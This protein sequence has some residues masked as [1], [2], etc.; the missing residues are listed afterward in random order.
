[1]IDR[2]ERRKATL[3]LTLMLALAGGCTGDSADGTVPPKG[4]EP[5]PVRLVAA[6]AGAL[7]RTV[8]ATGALAAEDQV[9]LN[10]KVAGRL[11]ELPVDLGS[12]VHQGDVVAVLDLTDLG[13]RAEQA[14]TALA[15]ARARLGAPLDG[16][17]DVIPPARTA[18]VRQAEA[19]LEQAR[20]QHERFAALHQEGILSKAELDRAE[21]ELRVAE[22]R[23]QEAFEEVRNRQA[24]IA[25]RRAEVGLARQALADATLRAPFDG[26][27]RERHLS[28]GG[29]LDVGAPVATIVRV[30]PLRLRLPVPERE[31]AALRT[32]Q[33][34][35][36]AIEGHDT[37][38]EGT[39][40]RL[41]PAVDESTR[42]LLVE[43]EVANAD[44]ALRPGAFARAEIVVDPAEPAILVPASAVVTFAGV[45]KVLGVED[46]RIVEHR[47]RTGRRV[48]DKVEVL[49]GV[50]AGDSVVAEPGTLTTGQA[51]APM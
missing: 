22:A 5:R 41:S 46:G 51:V 36:L 19:V 31:A 42:T 14:E 21:S 18:L 40:V 9:V 20:L 23:T 13:L 38:A 8:T 17:A 3:A 12:V 11:A 29:Y 33:T 15:Q 45:T 30:R 47:I 43:A 48:G 27:V 7:P 25:Q 6:E 28:I 2:A 35:H 16:S 50:A 39:L 49:E 4:E 10:T 44:G 24:M 32:G 37:I 1:M 26:V 34:V